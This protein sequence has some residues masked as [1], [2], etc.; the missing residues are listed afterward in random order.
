MHFRYLVFIL[1][2]NFLFVSNSMAEEDLQW[3]QQIISNPDNIDSQSAPFDNNSDTYDS[4]QQNDNNQIIS[5]TDKSEQFSDNSEDPFFSSFF[6]NVSYDSEAEYYIPP[7]F[8]DKIVNLDIAS[9][10]GQNTTIQAFNINGL[11]YF[12]V[13]TQRSDMKPFV[14]V[15]R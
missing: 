6:D 12:E 8:E 7:N 10:N 2:F 14:K 1:C 5:T 3:L 15:F 4:W 11:S 13:T 9:G